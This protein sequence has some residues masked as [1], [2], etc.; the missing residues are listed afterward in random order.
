MAPMRQT[1]YEMVG[2][3]FG[4]KGRDGCSEQYFHRSLIIKTYSAFEANL[5]QALLT[6]P[7]PNFAASNFFAV[8]CSLE[9]ITSSEQLPFPVSTCIPT[10]RSAISIG[11]ALNVENLF[12]TTTWETRDWVQHR[13]HHLF[14]E[15]TLTITVAEFSRYDR[16]CRCRDST[17]GM[18]DEPPM[19]TSNF[20]RGPLRLSCRRSLFP[21]P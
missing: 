10:Y 18:S 19:T 8:F 20:L 9:L 13:S 4:Q 5:A 3:R 12:P 11:T 21:S 2:T 7:L 1:S 14:S 6:L 15:S 17:A 16:R